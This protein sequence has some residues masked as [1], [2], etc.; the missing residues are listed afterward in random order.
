MAPKMESFIS[1]SLPTAPGSQGRQAR[2]GGGVGLWGWQLKSAVSEG[3][4]GRPWLLAPL[5]RL[6][7]VR[8]CVAVRFQGRVGRRPP[9]VHPGHLWWYRIITAF[10]LRG[11]VDFI[12]VEWWISVV[13]CEFTSLEGRE[14]VASSLC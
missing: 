12:A 5:R 9:L 1:S 2:K 8:R 13:W 14:L 10:L 6:C 3:R 4:L 7:L 11:G